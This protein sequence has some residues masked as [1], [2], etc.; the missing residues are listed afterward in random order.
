MTF[1]SFQNTKKRNI[2]FFSLKRTS[3]IFC[4]VLSSDWSISGL[5]PEDTARV[6]RNR[7]SKNRDNTMVKTNKNKMTKDYV[8]ELYRELEIGEHE[9]HK[10]PEVNT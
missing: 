2:Y 4:Y 1:N 3:F 9:P 5:T 7:K 6:I 8:Q 10:I